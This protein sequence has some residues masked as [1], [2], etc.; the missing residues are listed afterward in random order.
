MIVCLLFCSSLVSKF[1]SEA[2]HHL[3]ELGC[4][5]HLGFD[6]G[7]DRFPD[8][9]REQ[10]KSWS[11]LAQVSHHGFR[12]F[13]K[14]DDDPADQS[15]GHGIHLLHDPRQ[16]QD[17]DII[18]AW[19][20]WVCFEVSDTMFKHWPGLQH[21]Q[22][23]IGSRTRCRAENRYI[24]RFSMVDQLHIELGLLFVEFLST[25]H[26]VKMAHQSG[27]FILAHTA[28]IAVNDMLHTWTFFSDLK[29]LIDLLF[30][31]GDDDLGA[32]IVDQVGNLLIERILVDAE[33]HC[34]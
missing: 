17:R 2:I 15:L 20:L 27:I 8:T 10:H 3:L 26:Q 21:G 13:N 28:R 11:D 30:I 7:C 19:I 6:I 33:Y 31:L 18:I 5:H 24:F 4:I 14:V 25:G 29:N 9:R 12:L 22:L 1:H 34:P 16:R 23:R 32:S